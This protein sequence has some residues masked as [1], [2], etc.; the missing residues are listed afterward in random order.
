LAKSREPRDAPAPRADPPPIPG[1]LR[2]W[3]MPGDDDPRPPLSGRVG[4]DAS[5]ARDA[6]LIAALAKGLTREAAAT[7]A[8]CSVR[9][10]YARLGDPEFARA[11]KELRHEWLIAALGKLTAAAGQAADALTGLLGADTEPKI[12]HAA[13]K[14]IFDE[15]L[16]IKAAADTSEQ[17]AALQARVQLLQEKQLEDQRK[18][19]R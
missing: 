2:A 15:L 10:V 4:R 13:A 11:V 6:F 8:R 9:T 17:I 18:R 3:V 16:S 19:Q 14:T 5:R 1:P 7:E 12:R